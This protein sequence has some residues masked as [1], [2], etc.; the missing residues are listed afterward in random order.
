M[1]IIEICETQKLTLR[2]IGYSFPLNKA[3]SATRWQGDNPHPG[4][5]ISITI[6][7]TFAKVALCKIKTIKSRE[8]CDAVILWCWR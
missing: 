3:Q 6:S 4:K 5:A 7:I 1:K 2:H 8:D